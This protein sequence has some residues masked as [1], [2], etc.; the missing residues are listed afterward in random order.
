MSVKLIARWHRPFRRSKGA[1]NYID[2]GHQTLQTL[3]I[4]WLW[5]SLNLISILDQ[6]GCISI[7]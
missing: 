1:S 7:I 3:F 4:V 6:T 2:A 5:I